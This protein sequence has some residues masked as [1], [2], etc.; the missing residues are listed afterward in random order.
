MYERCTYPTKPVQPCPMPFL[1]FQGVP[2]IQLHT[3]FKFF[4]GHNYNTL[5]L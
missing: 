3:P 2:T 4:E 1:H 5:N